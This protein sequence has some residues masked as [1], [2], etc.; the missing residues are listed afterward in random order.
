M[1][2]AGAALYVV[3]REEA[4]PSLGKELKMQNLMLYGRSTDSAP[5]FLTDPRWLICTLNHEKNWAGLGHCFSNLAAHWSQLGVFIKSCH[6]GLTLRG[7]D[8]IGWG[9][10]N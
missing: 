1:S 5:E 8:L 10:A 3:H 7:S 2:Q 9:V 6:L 4:L